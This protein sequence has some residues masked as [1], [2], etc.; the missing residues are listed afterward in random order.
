M[1]SILDD[2]KITNKG[3]TMIEMVENTLVSIGLIVPV[4]TPLDSQEGVDEQAYRAVIQRCLDAGADGIFAGGSAGMGPLLPDSQWHLAMEIARDAVPPTK[5]LVGGVIATSTVRARQKIR[6]LESLKFESMAITP[7]FYIPTSSEAEYLAYFGACRECS[8]IKMVVYNIP[9]FTGGNIPTNVILKMAEKKWTSLIKES[10]GDR[11]Y[12]SSLLRLCRSHDVGVMQ[13]H[14]PDIAWGLLEGAAGIVPVCANYEPKTYVA[15]IQAA[16]KK[17]KTLLEF[18]QQRAS[19]LRHL[20]SVDRANW[21][22]GI[23]YGISSLGIGSGKPIHPLIELSD[24]EKMQIDA[25]EPYDIQNLQ[26]K[27]NVT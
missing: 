6:A 17:D 11:G 2:L 7:P 9:S 18:A 25:I 23:M 8:N 4:I 14:E 21:I 16:R 5:L 26:I 3:L 12:F 10:S 19:L 27:A 1:A 22:A 20:L 24:Q 15:A 13:G